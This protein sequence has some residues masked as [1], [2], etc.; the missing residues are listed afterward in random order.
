MLATLLLL[1]GCAANRL[2]LEN[3][4]RVQKDMSPA[5]VKAIL[6]KPDKEKG[7]GLSV[8]D[9][10]ATGSVMVWKHGDKVATITFAR[11]KVVLKAQTGLE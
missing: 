5:E 10:D 7:G 11:G 3:Y 9:I 8:G 4:N 1:C 2:T 6:G